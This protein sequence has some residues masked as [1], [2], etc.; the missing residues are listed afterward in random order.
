[1]LLYETYNLTALNYEFQ[2]L[3]RLKN[4]KIDLKFCDIKT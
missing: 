3:Q 1:M 2:L 4:T